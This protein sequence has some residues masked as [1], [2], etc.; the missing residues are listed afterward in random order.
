MH[1]LV[2]RLGYGGVT[3]LLTGDLGEGDEAE[4]MRSSA[5]LRSTVLKVGTMG[6]KKERR[7][8]RAAGGTGG[9]GPLGG[10]GQPVRPPGARGAG[11]VGGGAGSKDP[12]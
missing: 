7:A 2:L 1:R 4:L 12:E 5:D 10:Q 9:G 3:F 8:V 11:S 6:A